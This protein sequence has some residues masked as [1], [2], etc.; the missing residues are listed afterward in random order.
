MREER[1]VF[2]W[3]GWRR[4]GL[5]LAAGTLAL[6]GFGF[7][8]GVRNGSP[9]AA[10]AVTPGENA[11]AD[12]FSAFSPPPEADSIRVLP[13][14]T[15][16][17]ITPDAGDAGDIRW[18]DGRPVR[19]AGTRRMTV[20]A[21]SPD[22]RSCSPFADGFTASGYSVWTN[23]MKMVAADE[24][25]LAFGSLVSIPGYHEGQPV[26]VLDRGG[27]IRGDRLDVLLPT[28][29]QALAWGVRAID[30]VIWEYADG[31]PNGFRV[32]W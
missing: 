18:F 26:P 23:G 20:T 28:H 24:A 32:Q 2:A 6:V 13:I 16:G 7:G 4:R 27:R 19:P 5:L 22:E 31:K 25:V 8:A 15:R 10:G 12:L 29:E 3:Q 21:Y 17:R 30:V 14:L 9:S 11:A 1:Y